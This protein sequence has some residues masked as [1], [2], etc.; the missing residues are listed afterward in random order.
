MKE[1]VI[2]G[3]SA[4]CVPLAD[5]DVWRAPARPGA[6]RTSSAVFAGYL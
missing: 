6:A 2:G 4:R 5:I 1:S 3:D